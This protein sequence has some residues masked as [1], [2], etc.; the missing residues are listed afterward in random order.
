MPRT[1]T[2]RSGRAAGQRVFRGG[3]SRSGFRSFFSWGS[4][5]MTR[6][7]PFAGNRKEW[8]L[9]R[10]KSRS[11]CYTASGRKYSAVPPRLADSPLKRPLFSRNVG[12]RTALTPLGLEP[13]A[14]ECCAAS[15]CRNGLSVGDPYFL[16]AR[17]RNGLLHR[18][19]LV[20][21]YAELYQITMVNLH[22]IPTFQRPLCVV[23]CS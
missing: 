11:C 20:L 17:P 22:R 16:S 4:H 7:G 6:P 10:K 5:L 23:Q 8:S 2:G 3:R 15:L 19:Y 13:R 18:F 1:V 21:L 14:P 12:G 9:R